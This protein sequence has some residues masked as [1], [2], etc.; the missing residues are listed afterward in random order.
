MVVAGAADFNL[1][2]GGITLSQEFDMIETKLGE[3]ANDFYA[4]RVKEQNVSL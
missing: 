2:T 1:V 4:E 3:I